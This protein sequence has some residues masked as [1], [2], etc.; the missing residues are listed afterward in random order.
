VL[1]QTLALLLTAT[2]ALA[3][4]I[5]DLRTF[6]IAN[7]DLRLGVAI[8]WPTC[9]ICEQTPHLDLRVA[10]LSG[11]SLFLGLI[12]VVGMGD[13][14]LFLLFAPWL[15]QRNWICGAIA[16]ISVSWVQFAFGIWK[17]RRIPTQIAFAPA[18]L[19]AVAVN[20]AT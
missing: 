14:K 6:Q 7:R 2:W 13:V 18:I 19:I 1:S 9:L 17:S 12:G 11:A 8:C 4:A 20:M 3:V 16:L 15:H 5:R 10:L